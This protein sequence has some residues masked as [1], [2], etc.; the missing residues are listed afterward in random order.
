MFTCVGMGDHS[1]AVFPFE[2]PGHSIVRDTVGARGE[3]VC[4][5]VLELCVCQRWPTRVA[6]VLVVPG[7]RCRPSRA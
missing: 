7:V 3:E 5:V 1:L 4:H 2:D 6:A